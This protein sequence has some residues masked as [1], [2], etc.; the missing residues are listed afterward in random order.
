MPDFVLPTVANSTIQ[1][2]VNIKTRKK[3]NSETEKIKI[4]DNWEYILFSL[5]SFVES[6][7]LLKTFTASPQ[8][9]LR[10]HSSL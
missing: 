8:A 10:L 5:L 7:V 9:S 2:Y 6:I 3:I 1:N 4:A